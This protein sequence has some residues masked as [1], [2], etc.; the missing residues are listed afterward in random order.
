MHTVQ[1]S[2]LF[3]YTPVRRQKAHLVYGSS[4]LTFPFPPQTVQTERGDNSSKGS[5]PVPLQKAHFISF[6]IFSAFQVKTYGFI[7]NGFTMN[8]EA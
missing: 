8:G 1:L 6:I 7:L 3:G 2:L 5:T 4:T